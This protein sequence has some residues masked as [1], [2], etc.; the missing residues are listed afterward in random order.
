MKYLDNLITI[1]IFT[2]DKFNSIVFKQQLA[3][4]VKIIKIKTLEVI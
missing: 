4:L 1:E 2:I 3:R